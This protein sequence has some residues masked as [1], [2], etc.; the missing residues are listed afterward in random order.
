MLINHLKSSEITK[1]LKDNPKVGGA[2][3]TISPDLVAAKAPPTH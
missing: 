1:K 3:A 2:L